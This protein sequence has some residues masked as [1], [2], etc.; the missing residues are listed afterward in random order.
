MLLW[1]KDDKYHTEDDP[2]SA[3]KWNGSR[4]CAWRIA[5]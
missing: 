4:C 2:S 1:L 5:F 3:A